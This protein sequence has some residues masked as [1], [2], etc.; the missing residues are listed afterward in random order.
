MHNNNISG[1]AD[2]S[3]SGANSRTK[4]DIIADFCP[5]ALWEYVIK[6]KCA[7]QYKK[8]EGRFS[9]DLEPVRNFRRSM[10]DW[11]V[12][13]PDDIPIFNEFC[14]AL[15]RG[16]DEIDFVIRQF[17]DNY[18]IQQL[19]FKGK[20]IY[21]EDGLPKSV[22][23][24]TECLSD[25]SE[26]GSPEDCDA[27]TG[28]NRL[29]Y[30]SGVISERLSALKKD[31]KAALVILDI[32]DFKEINDRFGR[33]YGDSVIEKSGEFFSSQAGSDN[34][35]ARIAADEFMIFKTYPG[36][37]SDEDIL[38]D[39]KS[40]TN[41]YSEHCF[42]RGDSHT[43]SA[44][45][46][47]SDA[48][49]DFDLLYREADIALRCVKT[50][51]K[52][53][54]L[55]YSKEQDDAVGETTSKNYRTSSDEKG[56]SNLNNVGKSIFDF[57]LSTFSSASTLDEAADALFPEIGKYFGLGRIYAIGKSESGGIETIC[58]WSS[59]EAGTENGYISFAN[60]NWHEFKIFFDDKHYYCVSLGDENLTEKQRN[61]FTQTDISAFF[62][63][64]FYEN[65]DLAGLISFERIGNTAKWTD[66][67]TTS[68]TAITKMISAY[69]IKFRS[70][71]R[72]NSSVFY[73]KA[74]LENQQLTSYA[75]DPTDYK[76]TYV[77]PYAS[78]TF[79]NAEIGKTCYKCIMNADSPCRHCPIP[80]F[81][82]DNPRPSA[83]AY[84]DCLDGWY[85]TTATKITDLNGKE[86]ILVCW[87]DVTGFIHRVRFKDTITGLMTYERFSAEALVLMEK[88]FSDYAVISLSVDRF[89]NF[90]ER[91][92][93]SAGNSILTTI[94]ECLT[95][96]VESGE[97]ICRIGG[98]KFA[99]LMHCPDIC[100]LRDKISAA[101]KK[102][103]DIIAAEYSGEKISLIA[104]IYLLKPGDSILSEGIDKANIARKTIKNAL[105]KTGY[106]TAV[107]DASL[108]EMLSRRK[109]LEEIMYDAL[110]NDEFK[111]YYQPKISLGTEKI[112]GAEALV[113]WIRP[114]G[115][116][117]SP[118]EFVPMFEE[119]GFIA[120]MDFAV[121]K[122]VFSDIR[123][124][125]DEGRNV[126]IVSVNVSREHLKGD[127]F[128]QKISALIREYR[129]SP[130]FI[131]LEI[132]ESMFSRNLDHL[133]GVI[134]ELREIGFSISVDDFGTGFSTLNLITVLPVDVLKVDGGFFKQNALSERDKAVVTSI[135][136][137]AKKLRLKVVSE[138]IE[139]IEQVSFLKHAG[140][141]AAQG[142]YYYRPLT[143]DKFESLITIEDKSTVQ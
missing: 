11:G 5:Y 54:C 74:M 33:F 68:F 80:Q 69:I 1:S 17:S 84:Y 127:D 62:R 67:E 44:G 114:D 140:C 131:E 97:L 119:N 59:D 42:D 101:L 141:D 72:L 85:T 95:E 38:S 142:Y 82:E 58:S 139:T 126:P 123:R 16:D 61:F 49:A 2:I 52:N 98:G 93:Y 107:Y 83:E 48:S 113:R 47:L 88:P 60:R 18:R 31:D 57:A 7:L 40:L 92:G 111:V 75:V 112:A 66:A 45:I 87:T 118:G 115:E 28:L 26:G 70:Q 89:R 137:L 35:T 103:R 77:S 13:Y 22:M 96:I 135:L 6:D 90:N 136:T 100:E 34:V 109:Y 30:A 23:G 64:P 117:I 105:S 51:S 73:T 120:E 24:C 32:D 132:T 116:I 138:G 15:D 9:G 143:S 3:G 63:C 99:G 19:R 81:S 27:L 79:P 14:D 129:I 106:G 71:K 125:I 122:R 104:G 4:A 8:L 86:N 53:G 25:T 130:R 91:E 39:I 94:A 128:P 43:V 108:D 121:Y 124:W 41:T 76:I 110:E 37:F 10:L 12:V 46:A 133:I 78:R 36:S 21:G 56:I 20:T 134:N 50:T 29:E 65:D 102:A 55:L